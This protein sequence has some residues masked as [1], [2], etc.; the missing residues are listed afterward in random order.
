MPAEYQITGTVNFDEY[1]EGH[2]IMAA[3][4][5]LWIRGICVLYGVG[6][7]IYGSLYAPVKTNITLPLVAAIIIAYGIVISPILFRY[8]VKRN[9]DRYP[10]LKDEFSM[11]IS[12]E[13]IVTLDDKG[14]PSH[15]NWESFIYHRESRSLFLLYYSPRLPVLIPKRLI[16]ESDLPAFRDL[17]SS[18]L[19]EEATSTPPTNVMPPA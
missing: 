2:K 15:T 3:K 14:N 1:L 16:P 18:A 10:K 6:I 19:R 7:V 11:K 9:W 12:P 5:R 17:L 4:R 8:R 13:G